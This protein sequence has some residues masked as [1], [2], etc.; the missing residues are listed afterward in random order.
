MIVITLTDFLLF[1]ILL[2]LLHNTGARNEA[3]A[4]LLYELFHRDLFR[5]SIT[6]DAATVEV[7][8]AI[9]VRLILLVTLH[10]KYLYYT[11]HHWS[12]CWFL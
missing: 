8:G 12:C 2:S 5:I 1:F 11:E 6:Q 10:I 9:K 4:K 7:C 3:N